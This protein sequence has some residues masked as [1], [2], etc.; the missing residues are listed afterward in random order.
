MKHSD[1]VTIPSAASITALNQFLAADLTP[2]VNRFKNLEP[3]EKRLADNQRL[4]EHKIKELRLLRRTPRTVNKA[5]Q[6]KMLRIEQSLKNTEQYGALDT[7]AGVSKTAAYL[8]ALCPTTEHQGHF[9]RSAAAT[10]I[11]D[12]HPPTQLLRCFGVSTS[13]EL[14]A[15]IDP[16]DALTIV[17]HT[18][19]NDWLNAYFTH[20]GACTAA[21]FE[22]RSVRNFVV[23]REQF[24]DTLKRSG[25]TVKPWRISHSKETGTINCFVLDQAV[26]YKTPLLQCT[27]VY[28]HYFFETAHAGAFV[29]KHRELT[30]EQVGAKLVE[31]IMG[32]QKK[33]PFFQDIYSEQLFWFRALKT[34]E[35]WHAGNTDLHFF[36]DTTCCGGY[37]GR[38]SADN[39]V[40]LNFVDVLWD[41]NIPQQHSD[42]GYFKFT[43][44]L[45]LYHFREGLWYEMFADLLGIEAETLHQSVIENLHIGDE[46]FT[47]TMIT[48][49]I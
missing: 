6:K 19:T 47:D 37:L 39:Q 46:A 7:Y 42:R 10:R 9:L 3:I 17:R 33:F 38:P 4:F 13:K 34:L 2:I 43:T 32:S 40:S 29:T 31:V 36:A 11:L 30:P 18:E 26:E 14:A 35:R 48:H 41:T 20:L 16:L 24:R 25:Q 45:F 8:H 12:A 27:A 23:D 1:E 22:L 15:H 21:D 5:L 44:P 49:N 28:L